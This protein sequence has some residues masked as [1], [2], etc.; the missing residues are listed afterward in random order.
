[1][2]TCPRLLFHGQQEVLGAGWTP[3]LGAGLSSRCWGSQIVGRA[4][5]AGDS[6]EPFWAGPRPQQPEH[7]EW[8]GRLAAPLPF[9][10]PAL[11]GS[12]RPGQARTGRSLRP[13]GGAGAAEPVS[14]PQLQ[15]RPHP[16]ALAAPADHQQLP[17]ELQAPA[18]QNA[19]DE[20]GS[21]AQT[22]RGGPLWRAHSGRPPTRR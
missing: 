10:T 17:N 9:L 18:D 14:W 15:S 4:A 21:P 20:K 11:P 7:T 8:R 2:K 19:V 1:M 6:L 5:R 3:S 12:P 22:R 16:L 13:W